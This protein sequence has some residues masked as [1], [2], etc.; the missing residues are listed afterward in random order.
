MSKYDLTLYHH[1]KQN[2]NPCRLTSSQDETMVRCP[3]CGDSKKSNKSTHMYIQNNTPFKYFCQRCNASGVMNSKVLEM[4]NSNQADIGSYINS[5]YNNYLSNLNRKYGKSFIDR[6][7]KI[8]DYYPDQYNELEIGKINYINERLGITISESDISLYKLILNINDF[9]RKNNF[10]IDNKLQINTLN[11]NYFSYMLNDRNTINCRKM[12]NEVTGKK[13]FKQKIFKNLAEE[14]N[15]FY[16]ITN[17]LVLDQNVYNVH[18]AEGFFDIISVFNHIHNREI[19]DNDLFIANNG[20][21]YKFVFDYL[22]KLGLLNM[23]I[24]IYSDKDVK[25]SDYK[26][27]R[28]LGNSIAVKLNDANIYYNLHEEEKDF[29]VPKD[30]IKISDPILFSSIK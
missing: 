17:N 30:R 28:M 5:E 2:V 6:N 23:N 26:S 12:F 21:G 7:T 15:R 13:H 29:G 27:Y 8:L 22:S 14:S 18:I 3:F 19:N 24:S 1:L 10:D 11:Q 20:K 16:S 25:L 9:Y 4:L